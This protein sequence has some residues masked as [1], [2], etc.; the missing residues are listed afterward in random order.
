MT[1]LIHETEQ[2]FDELRKNPQ[3]GW[4]PADLLARLDGVQALVDEHAH[5]NESVLGRK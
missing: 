5:I 1:N 3:A 4:Q 2:V